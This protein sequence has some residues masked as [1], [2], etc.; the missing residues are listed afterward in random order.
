MPF[1]IA[2]LSDLHLDRTHAPGSWDLA[3]AAFEA[4][5]S[6]DHVVVAGDLFDSA[7][8]MRRDRSHVERAL[9]T[10]GLWAADRLTLVVGN[11]DIFEPAH[12]GGPL[13]HV[14]SLLRVLRAG[15]RRNLD[16]LSGWFGELVPREDREHDD[17]VFPY[18]RRLRGVTLVAADST[19]R[20]TAWASQGSWD[21][22]EDAGVRALLE[23]APGLRVVA[24]HF[25]PERGIMPSSILERLRGSRAATSRPTFAAC[26]N[27]SRNSAWT[28]S[29]RGTST[30]A[31][32][33][34]HGISGGRP[35]ASW[36]AQ[37]LSTE[38][39]RATGSSRCFRAA[40]SSGAR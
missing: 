10:L 39:P 22:D 36:A 18:R 25:P 5:S 4:A 3:H 2:V 21:A 15:A 38:R 24:T 7:G 13:T 31:G 32:T 27:S 1:E 26:A 16:L 40:S 29:W 9:K 28:S 14:A 30:P 8:A 12:H 19:P 11:H 34:G 6:A 37:A 23:G 17:A 35:F 20:L 33:A